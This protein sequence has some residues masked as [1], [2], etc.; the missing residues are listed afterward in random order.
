MITRSSRWCRLSA[1]GILNRNDAALALVAICVTT[2]CVHTSATP[3]RDVLKL[4]ISIPA[5]GLQSATK[6]RGRF[7][8]RNIAASAIEVCEVDSGVNVVAITDR[9]TFPLVGHGVT[10]DAQQ[11]C[12][13]LRPGEMKE[14]SEEFTWTP[15]TALEQLRASIRVSGR[16]GGDP[17]LITS[18]RVSASQ[19][20]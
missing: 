12:Y 9:G 5:T 1:T 14:F 8:L 3:L 10:F 6:V 2:G 4:E 16:R 11:I 18:I 17:V 13:E 20:R 15:T 19:R 7:S